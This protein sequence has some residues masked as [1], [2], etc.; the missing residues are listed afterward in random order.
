MGF[1]E[2]DFEVTTTQEDIQVAKLLGRLDMKG[3]S[4]IESKFSF[5]IGATKNSAI[6]DMSEVD[7]LA[8][9]GMRMLISAARAKSNRG[10]KLVLLSPTPLVKEALIKAGFD[11]LLP[12]VDDMDTAMSV[13]SQ[14]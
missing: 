7:F 14:D 9:I 1:P 3:V 4:E 2:M 12:I 6:V 11:Q 5:A 10:Y 8:S 13:L